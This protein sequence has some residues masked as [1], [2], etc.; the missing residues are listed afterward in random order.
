MRSRRRARLIVSLVIGFLALGVLSSG[1][2]ADTDEDAE[3]ADTEAINELITE[4][5]TEVNTADLDGDGEA[6]FADVDGDGF[7]DASPPEGFP[8]D[9]DLRP[10][11]G[12]FGTIVL[13]DLDANAANY[14]EET[15]SSYLLSTVPGWRGRTTATAIPSTRRSASD[16]GRA[17]DRPGRSGTSIRLPTSANA[18]SRRATRS[19]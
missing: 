15:E 2:A 18:R 9:L 17:A 19:S 7:P 1:A 8:G 16:P 3:P 4:F 14:V 5:M 6:D 12:R 13:A 11:D 10:G